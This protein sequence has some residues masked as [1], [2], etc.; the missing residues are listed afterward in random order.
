MLSVPAS[1]TLVFTSVMGV[2][3]LA[4]ALPNVAKGEGMPLV[5]LKDTISLRHNA[6]GQKRVQQKRIGSA[7]PMPWVAQRFGRAW[8]CVESRLV[9]PTAWCPVDCHVWLK[10]STTQLQPQALHIQP[11]C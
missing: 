11:H 10:H 3:A 1:A 2:A 7:A 9:G 8:Q 5:V 6:Q 4:A